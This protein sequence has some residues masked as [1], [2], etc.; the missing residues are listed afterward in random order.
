MF[1]IYIYYIEKLKDPPVKRQNIVGVYSLIL[2]PTLK[3][4]GVYFQEF[5]LKF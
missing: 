5:Y 1:N 3:F 4:I 2:K